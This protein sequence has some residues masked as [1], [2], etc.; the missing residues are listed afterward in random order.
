MVGPPREVE[1]RRGLARLNFSW[2]HRF[3]SLY[4]TATSVA[5]DC[6]IPSNLGDEKGPRFSLAFHDPQGVSP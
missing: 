4:I 3:L 1:E 5:T 2:C 6:P